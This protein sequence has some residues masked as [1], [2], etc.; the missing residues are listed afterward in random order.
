MPEKKKRFKVLMQRMRNRYRL[1]VMNDDTF[2]EK[3]SLRSTPLGLTIIITAISIFMIVLVISIVAFTPLRNY[4]P[5]YGNDYQVK[6][7]LIELAERTD[8]LEQ[9][10][11]QNAQFY[12]NFKRVISGEILADTL[13][14]KPNNE[15]NYNN[16]NLNPSKEDSVLRNEVE[17]QGK[18]S[19]AFN[20]GKQNKTG[21]S[22]FFFFTPVKGTITSSFDNKKEHFGVDVAAP[23]N[24]A[25]KATL[26][27]TV[28]FTGWSA[29]TGHVVHLQH[30]NNLIS[31]YKHNSKLMKKQGQYVKAGD[32]IAIIGN[33]GEQSTGTHL[34]FELWYNGKA[35][36]PQDYMAF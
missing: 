2:E 21:I 19:L 22:S 29:E 14:N 30:N 10:T 18:Y 16:V 8:S 36:D 34:H 3:L 24:E 31:I 28:I 4:I 35:V 32:V 33:T 5:G 26:D 13:L 1:V 6:K 9:V 15:K 7:Q 17:S 23:E 11:K 27:G 20:D 12:E 25:I